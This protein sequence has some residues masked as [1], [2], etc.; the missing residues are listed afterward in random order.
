MCDT[1]TT[2][3]SALAALAAILPLRMVAGPTPAFGLADEAPHITFFLVDVLGWND[4]SMHTA[5][6]SCKP[7]AK[8]HAGDCRCDRHMY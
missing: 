2:A 8:N 1:T 6:R 4:V 7:L 3:F 5:V